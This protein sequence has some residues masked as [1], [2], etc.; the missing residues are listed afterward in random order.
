[1]R[2]MHNG[3]KFLLAGAAVMAVMLSGCDQ[4]PG[5]DVAATTDRSEIAT[6]QA[7]ADSAA[8]IAAETGPEMTGAEMTDTSLPELEP[9]PENLPQLAYDYDYGWALPA[10]DIGP[11]QRT[12]ANLCEQQGPASCQITGMSKTGEEAE[13]VRGILEMR[14][15]ARQARAFGALLEDEAEDAGAEL[16]SAE[17]AA[18]ELSKQIVDTEARLR[19]REALRD[20]LSEVLRTRRGSID[21]LVEAERS[22]AQVNQEIDQARSWLKQMEGRVAYSKVTVRYETGAPVTSDFLKPVQATLGSLGS[23]MG[24]VLAIMIVLGAII[25]PVAGFVWAGRKVNRRFASTS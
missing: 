23:I 24:W 17:I 8:D 20:R 16:V 14:V 3:Q 15:A 22:V 7:E 11:L 10:E 19:T 13:D 9:V 21:E 1:M 5:R 18:E 12:H 2:H 6:M 4:G 25:A